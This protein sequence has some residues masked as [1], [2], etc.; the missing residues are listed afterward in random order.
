M[1]N[2]NSMNLK[3]S[4]A[5][6]LAL[7]VSGSAGA[8]DLERV[9]PKKPAGKTEAGSLG[10]SAPPLAEGKGD[11]SSAQG[12]ALKGIVIVKSRDEVRKSGDLDV[13][14]LKI[15]AGDKLDL[16]RGPDFSF[17]LE[18]FIGERVTEANIRNIQREIIIYYRSHRRSVVDVVV[19][20]QTSIG[21][22]VLQI[23]VME[24]SLGK[25]EVEGNRWTSEELIAK[26]LHLEEGAAINTGQLLEDINW[27]NRNPGRQISPSLRPGA[28]VGSS[29]VV[30]QVEES[31]PFRVFAG[32]E[33]TGPRFTGSERFFV[34]GNWFNAFGADHRMS[35]QFTSDVELQYL[36]A[37]SASYEIPLPWR[38]TVSVYGGYSDAESDFPGALAPTQDATSWQ[39]SLRYNI[40]LPKIRSYRHSLSLGFDF[41]TFNNDLIFLGIPGTGGTT[42]VD[43]AQ[44]AAQYQGSMPDQYGA[45]SGGISGYYSPGDLLGGNNDDVSF[46][47]ARA[48]SEADY[49]YT[50]TSMERQTKLPFQM[51]WVIRAQG[52]YAGGNLQSSEQLGLGGYA[53][54]RGY[55]E[56]EGNGDIGYIVSNE[57]HSPTFS[58]ASLISE[59]A[60]D[61][62]YFLGFYDY[63][64]VRPV[65]IPSV[66][67]GQDPV[68][69]MDSVGL[70]FRY[71]VGRNFTLRFD[72]GWQLRDSG[73]LT[74]LFGQRKNSSRGHVGATVSF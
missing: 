67:A 46:A 40:P 4:I 63:G 73:V 13:S 53:T 45:T 61:R 47:G 33:N 52:Q 49:M 64:E 56:R 25:V 58:P 1:S 38:H 10:V 26:N 68:I 29:D 50:R 55:D 59:N 8:V 43:I 37:H 36:K 15:G 60:T 23:F 22:G 35:Y 42:D 9:A 12:P 54:V 18:T 57:I 6:G 39:A 48:A 28:S 62:L 31:R 21:A 34:G 71:A 69:T 51:S 30:L 17:L 65:S 3:L 20:E 19:P 2:G 14:G 66:T 7:A 74:G 32:V 70:G 24:G 11:A 44:F 5:L 41:K 16:L 72:Y 27:L